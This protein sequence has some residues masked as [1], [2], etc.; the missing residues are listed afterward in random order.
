MKG[1][2]VETTDE[3]WVEV[4]H[5]TSGSTT[6]VLLQRDRRELPWEGVPERPGWDGMSFRPAMEY[7]AWRIAAPVVAQ[8]FNSRL[9]LT[10]HMPVTLQPRSWPETRTMLV[11]LDLGLALAA[12]FARVHYQVGEKPKWWDGTLNEGEFAL[13][14]YRRRV[15][16]VVRLWADDVIAGCLSTA[17]EPEG[18]AVAGD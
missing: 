12:L 4:R 16:G 10:E 14:D 7:D 17:Y 8:V 1:F 13:A 3:R 2:G 18:E 15:D 5:S 9:N 6:L 11:R